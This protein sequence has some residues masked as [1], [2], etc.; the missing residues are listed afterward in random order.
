MKRRATLAGGALL[1]ALVAGGVIAFHG[2]DGARGAA[3]ATAPAPPERIEVDG[4]TFRLSFSDEFESLSLWNGTAGTWRTNYGFFDPSRPGYFTLTDNGEKQL[5]VDAAFKGQ[6]ASPLGLDPF[7]V[8]DGVLTITAR[9]LPASVSAKAWN[10]GYGSGLITTKPSFA[11]TYGWFEMRARLP[12]GKGLWPAF[13]LAR[14]DGA[15]P[16]ELD[17]MEMLGDRPGRIYTTVHSKASGR[18]ERTGGPVDVP[19]TSEGFHTYG[20]KW[21]PATISWFVDRTKVFEAPTPAD[22]HKPMYLLANL[23]VGGKWPG[24]P[25]PSTRFPAEMQID[26]IRAYALEPRAT[27][28]KR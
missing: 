23:A 22:M 8:R 16:P 21:T 2:R 10:Y 18:H 17:V 5:Y 6:A 1:L 26:Y 15:W 24:D 25:D 4:E 3:A 9:P 28:D 27:A 12:R 20:V 11:Q 19:D 7:A 14:K 13:W